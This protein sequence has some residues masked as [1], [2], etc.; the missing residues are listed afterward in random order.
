L[1]FAQPDIPW[2]DDDFKV[3][4]AMATY[5]TNFIKTGN[6]DGPNSDSKPLPHWP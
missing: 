4:D 3:S 6:P 5:W 2:A 1:K